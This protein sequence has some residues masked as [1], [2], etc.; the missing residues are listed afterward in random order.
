MFKKTKY[1][2]AY[3]VS[4]SFFQVRLPISIKRLCACLN[5]FSYPLFFSICSLKKEGTPVLSFSVYLPRH[6]NAS[7]LSLLHIMKRRGLLDLCEATLQ[8]PVK[9]WPDAAW[10]S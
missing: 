3:D 8:R 2:F 4:L 1:E 9:A 5:I 10:N 7:Q 6:S